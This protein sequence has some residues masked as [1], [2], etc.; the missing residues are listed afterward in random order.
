MLNL[1]RIAS[2]CLLLIAALATSVASFAASATLFYRINSSKVEL[3]FS[4]NASFSQSAKSLLG[5]EKIS[6]T[7]RIK[8]R[9][10]ASPDGPLDFNR[11]LASERAW[12]TV[13]LLKHLN[14]AVPDSLYSVSMLDEDWAGVLAYL[15]KSDKAWAADALK[16]VQSGKADREDRLRELYV[17]EAWDDLAEN[18]FPR[19]RRAEVSVEDAALASVPSLDASHILASLRPLGTCPSTA[20]QVNQELA[21]SQ[22]LPTM[23]SGTCLP[24]AGEVNQ[25]LAESQ[26]FPI[27]RTLY[28]PAYSPTG[29]AQ[30]NAPPAFSQRYCA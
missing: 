6:G 20:G 21:E 27:I 11:K 16:I 10:C 2:I 17:G 26:Q 22:Q 19:L 13:D 5:G 30:S 28:L 23:H 1:K 15:R 14:P 12:A 3:N 9:A 8:V 7:Y 24:T 29:P 4:G 25:E 18:C